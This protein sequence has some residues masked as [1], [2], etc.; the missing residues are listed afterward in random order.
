MDEEHIWKQTQ[1]ERRHGR[2]WYGGDSQCCRESGDREAVRAGG[3]S[4]A[5]AWGRRPGHWLS[6]LVVYISVT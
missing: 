2:K 1:S 4:A 5:E 6:T 3:E